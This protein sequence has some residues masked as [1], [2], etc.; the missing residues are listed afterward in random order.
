MPIPRRSKFTIITAVIVSSVAFA[1]PASV[2]A[3]A[4]SEDDQYYSDVYGG[5]DPSYGY[6]FA[7]PYFYGRRPLHRPFHRGFHEGFHA[8]GFHGGVH[9][10]GGHGR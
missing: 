7:A 8:G 6:E 2:R 1:A 10:G 5:A 3:Q 4:Y 9:G